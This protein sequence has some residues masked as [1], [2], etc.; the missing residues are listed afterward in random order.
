MRFKKIPPLICFSLLIVYSCVSS[1]DKS[2]E[3][4][5]MYEK[6]AIEKYGDNIKYLFNAAHTYVLCIKQAQAG[7]EQ[8]FPPLKFFVYDLDSE[9]IVYEESLANG[10]VKWRND[11]QLEITIIPGIIKGNEEGVNYFIYDLNEGKR[12][13]PLL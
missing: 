8:P 6:S 4:E 10:S 13:Y 12:I 5:R 9:K 1:E 11:Y 7:T 2:T 3:G